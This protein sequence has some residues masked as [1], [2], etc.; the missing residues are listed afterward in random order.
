MVDRA[1]IGARA[2]AITN[3]PKVL[4]KR[5]EI[6]AMVHLEFFRLF[7]VLFDLDVIV[8]AVEWHMFCFQ[9]L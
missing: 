2:P 1:G 8:L 6:I 4:I 3:Y 5:V 7:V 9:V